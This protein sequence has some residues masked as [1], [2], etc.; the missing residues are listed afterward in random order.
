MPLESN[1]EFPLNMNTV[2][3]DEFVR[4]YVWKGEY[5]TFS[6][7]INGEMIGWYVFFINQPEKSVYLSA[8]EGFENK[9]CFTRNSETAVS[10]LLSMIFE[11]VN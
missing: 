11:L 4:L 8:G 3:A 10:E 7:T 1:R 6:G 2:R 5:D 9:F